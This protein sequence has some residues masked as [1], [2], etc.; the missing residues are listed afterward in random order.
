M[1]PGRV[2][3]LLALALI[4]IVGNVYAEPQ[5]GKVVTL[6]QA[7]ATTGDGEMTDISSDS[8]MTWACDVS[9]TGVPTSVTVRVE[10]NLGGTVF[11]TTGM[12]EHVL[13][14][15]Q[16]AITPNPFSSFAFS[17]GPARQIKGVL[18]T[19]AGGTSP[20]VTMKCY[21]VAK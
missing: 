13:T 5:P 14:A 16:L 19:L 20:T 10:G 3:F 1:R 9:T 11:D 12:A 7:K 4:L 21:G 17:V 2:V 15:A 8:L 6:L 18:V